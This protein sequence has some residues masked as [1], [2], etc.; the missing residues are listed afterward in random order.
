GTSQRPFMS[1]TPHTAKSL[2][3]DALEKAAPDERAA[4]LDEACAGD[5]ELRQRVEALLRA[6]NGSD[7]L[8]DRAAVEHLAADPTHHM[9]TADELALEEVQDC[10]APSQKPGSLGRLAHYE[11]M[12]VIGRGGMGVV[13]RAFDEKLHRIVAIK[14]LAP[15]LAATGG[16]RERFVRE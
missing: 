13:L 5:A 7:P 1:D 2:F 9:P 4:F 16:A 6:H 11:V 14:L 10:L 12:Q 15:H 3:L 8:L